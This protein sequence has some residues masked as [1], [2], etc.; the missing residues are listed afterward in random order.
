M[1]DRDLNQQTRDSLEREPVDAEAV[2]RRALFS[3]GTM[4]KAAGLA[5][6][7]LAMSR[8]AHAQLPSASCATL[9]V[10]LRGGMDALSAVFP[11][12]DASYVTLR[13][14]LAL[15]DPAPGGNTALDTLFGLSKAAEALLVPYLENR[16]AFVLG[17][18]SPSYSSQSHFAS[19][20]YSE[21]G[22][23]SGPLDGRG[24]LGRYLFATPPSVLTLDALG[25]GVSVQL[26]LQGGP[27]TLAIP[28]P[29][30]FDLNGDPVTTPDRKIRLGQIYQQTDDPAKA[31][32]IGSLEVIDDLGLVDFTTTVAYPAHPFGQ[33]MRK[34]AAL[35]RYD[36][37]PAGP[38]PDFGPRGMV[39]DFGGWD[40]HTEEGPLAPGGDYYDRL[41]TL[42]LGLRA[43]YDEMKA[44]GIEYQLFV[45]SEFGRRV[46][47][48]G[49]QGC[50]HGR[51]GLMIAMANAGMNGGRVYTRKANGTAGWGATGLVSQ[52]DG[53]VGG[54]T[55][56]LLCNIS[57]WDLFSEY[58]VRRCGV[59]ESQ[60]GEVFPG[61]VYKPLRLF[62]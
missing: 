51:G 4:L 15:A 25:F 24:W 62:L 35:L 13:Q 57:W 52:L 45:M 19:Q 60:L 44:A 41:Q 17:A 38:P 33:A 26:T 50:D 16:L 55:Q 37:P 10:Y 6:A 59:P 1:Q 8:R 58:L 28:D 31:A 30:A 5:T 18:G 47:M 53:Q 48:N 29:E 46:D 12:N 20:D 21:T 43:F 32:G 3:G 7:Y 14:A 36:N 27:K 22:V 9:V 23:Q 56:N 42:A 61:Y 39:I 2:S 49:N 11:F 34:A 54:T 40:D